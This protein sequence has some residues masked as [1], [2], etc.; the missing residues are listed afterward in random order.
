LINV[1]KIRQRAA[2]HANEFRNPQTWKFDGGTAGDVSDTYPNMIATPALFTTNAPSELYPTTV[3]TT[4]ERFIHFILNERTRELCGELYRWEDL[5]RTE[6]LYQ[7]VNQSNGTYVKDGVT[8][9][10]NPDAT[11]IQPHHKLRP[12]P[13]QQI[14]LVTLN[15]AALTTEQKKA[16][17]NPGY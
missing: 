16:Y 7:R 15:G 9:K 10:Y 14:E 17:Q 12:I 13:T 6:T 3:N 1:N 8:Y 2:Y 4:G 11:S 5:A